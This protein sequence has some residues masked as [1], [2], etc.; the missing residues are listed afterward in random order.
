[1]AKRNATSTSIDVPSAK[2]VL[3]ERIRELIYSGELAPGERIGVQEL[4]ER[5]GLSR[6]PVRDALWH[7]NSEGL[8]RIA[9]RV[10]VFVRQIPPQEVLEVYRMKGALEPIMA[11]WA[12]ERG[13]VAERTQFHRSMTALRRMARSGDVEGYVDLLEER[14]QS[15]LDMARSAVLAD[16]LAVIDGRVRM[17]RHRNL[18]Q[19]GA[20]RVSVRQHGE[21]AAAV[22]AG[23]AQRAF[24]AMSAHMLDATA[25]VRQLLDLPDEDSAGIGGA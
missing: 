22:H 11:S 15:L 19:P 18:S 7:L 17:L 25:R 6:T 4:A 2:D 16:E 21:V 14:R 10:G 8:L 13:T 23:D 24:D 5:F 20:L 3:V 9:P 1:M 12:A